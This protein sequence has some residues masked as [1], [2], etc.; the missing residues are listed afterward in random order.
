MKPFD[1]KAALAGEPVVTRIGIP[2]SQL[3]V[4]DQVRNEQ[5]IRGV[6]EG[7]ITGWDECGRYMLC[8]ASDSRDLFMAPK[9]RTVWVNLYGSMQVSCGTATYYY[10]EKQAN[11]VASPGRIGNRAYPIEIKE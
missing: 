7:V 5:P 2:V 4:F 9:K 1:L 11:I 3:V 10:D 8:K 6:L